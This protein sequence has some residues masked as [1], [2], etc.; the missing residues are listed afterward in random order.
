VTL[1]EREEEVALIDATLARASRGHGGLLTIEGPPGIGKTQLLAAA[2]QHAAAKGALAVSARASELEAGL[3][4]QVVR[5]LFEPAAG[6][7]RTDEMLSGSGATAV[8]ESLLWFTVGLAD[9]RPVLLTVDDAQWSDRASLCFLAYLARRLD[10]VRALIAIARRSGEEEDSV[11]ALLRSGDS[12]VLL[13]RPLSGDATAALVRSVLGDELDDAFCHACQD[14]SQGNPLL[15]R[16]LTR[17]VRARG[18][19]PTTLDELAD[20]GAVAIGRTVGAR[21]AVLPPAATAFAEAAA[22]MGDGVD[23]RIAAALADLPDDDADTAVVALHRADILIAGARVAFVH[24]LV[25]E[26]LRRRIAPLAAERLHDRAASL[27]RDNGAPAVLVAGLLVHAGAARGLGTADVETLRDAA[28]AA[29]AGGDPRSA[30][31]FLGHLLERAPSSDRLE[32]LLELADAERLVDGLAATR[33]LQE[34]AELAADPVT[35][36]S[37]LVRVAAV[38]PRGPEESIAIALRAIEELGTLDPEVR[39]QLLAVAGS[40]VALRPAAAGPHAK[41]LAAMHAAA[42]GTSTPGDRMLAAVLAYFDVWSGGPVSEALA[43]GAPAFDGNWLAACSVTPTP[44]VFGIMTMLIADAPQ[45]HRVIAE[46]LAFARHEGSFAFLG[47]ALML[48]GRLRLGGGQVPEAVFDARDALEAFAGWGVTGPAVAYA[49][50]VLAEAALERGELEVAERAC[51]NPDVATPG[52]GGPSEPT[53]LL[54]RAR[55]RAARGDVDGA[56]R[57]TLTLGRDLAERGSTS[58][59]AVPW[60]SQAALLTDDP[61]LARRL[62]QAEVADATVARS[63]R[64]LGRALTALGGVN[65]L[66]EAIDVL[67][68][69]VA[70]LEHARAQTALGRVHI[71]AGSPADARTPLRLA[72]EI[73]QRCEAIALENE[74][75]SLLLASGARPRRAAQSGPEALTAAERRVAT[76]AAAGRSNREIARQLYLAPRTVETHL[77]RSYRK[78]GIASRAQLRAAIGN[79]D[80]STDLLPESVSGS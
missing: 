80:V 25:R 59:A 56:L 35:R 7:E 39:R 14:L 57:E 60:R 62:A 8:L 10:G 26:A 21:L 16:E 49:S 4:Y 32:V 64:A 34:A 24:P 66:T 18:V 50:A 61:E 12:T 63:P 73:A 43:I 23:L 78:L 27:L 48:R 67:E 41:L 71:A 70:P 9:E 74:A 2:H 58:A 37:L 3:P 76:L 38:H 19:T 53:F 11:D 69:A 55:V 77:T 79:H 1:L 51:A 33:H 75:R 44:F 20:V 47:G 13:P 68:S 30:Q 17:G 28:R 40:A 54:A 52:A 15:L 5:Q 45:A 29:A 6:R 72:L 65:A 31:R 36:A 46:F 42:A 22:V